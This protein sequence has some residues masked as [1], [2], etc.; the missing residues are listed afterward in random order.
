MKNFL[1]SVKMLII[2]IITFIAITSNCQAEQSIRISD[3]GLDRFVS[4]YNQNVDEFKS[5]FNF[6]YNLHMNDKI[7]HDKKSSDNIYD[8][9]HTFS[10]S[11]GHGTI[12]IFYVNKE[13]YV[14][15]VR[16]LF[17]CT[18]EISALAAERIN[19]ILF[20]TIGFTYD[21]ILKYILPNMQKSPQS[22]KFGFYCM[23][24]KR[25]VYVEKY[26]QDNGLLR[27]DLYARVQ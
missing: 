9:Y 8:V 10:G 24:T 15:E 18:D 6:Q 25:I 2:C 3:Y 1:K 13:G 14:S 21:E 20:R 4:E 22:N 12:V 7:F 27:I 5:K 17:G 11:E 23:A 16:L 19:I 26:F